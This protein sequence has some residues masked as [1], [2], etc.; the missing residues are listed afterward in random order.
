MPKRP[1]TAPVASNALVM[2]RRPGSGNVRLDPLGKPG[3]GLD[4]DW[5]SN[6]SS[7]ESQTMLESMEGGTA[8]RAQSAPPIIFLPEMPPPDEKTVDGATRVA[9]AG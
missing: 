8:A 7:D 1:G 4:D 6:C 9:P 3:K 5:S 2:Q